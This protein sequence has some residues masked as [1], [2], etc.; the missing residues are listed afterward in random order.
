MCSIAL[1]LSI[2]WVAAKVLKVDP[3]FRKH[4]YC[5]VALG[6]CHLPHN[7]RFSKIMPSYRVNGNNGACIK[8][9]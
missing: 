5:T 4:F 2:G 9:L 3:W 8:F 1:G 6:K 7:V